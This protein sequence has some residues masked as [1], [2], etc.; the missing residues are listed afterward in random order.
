MILATT[1]GCRCERLTAGVFS[2]VGP[3]RLWEL[4]LADE[5]EAEFIV[6]GRRK[7]CEGRTSFQLMQSIHHVVMTTFERL[8]NPGC[9]Q[10]CQFKKF[11]RQTA[12]PSHRVLA[13]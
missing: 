8:V 4:I 10:D 1:R 7:T 9:F 5:A 12:H 3:S 6:A 11:L 13:E 2:C